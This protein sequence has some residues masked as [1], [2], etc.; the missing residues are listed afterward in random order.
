MFLLGFKRFIAPSVIKFFYYLALFVAVLSA[1][2]VVL[3]ALVEMRTLGAPQ[4]GAMIAGAAIG[5]P[6][7]ILLMRFSTEM[8][9]VLFEI[10]SR[11]GQI[12]DKL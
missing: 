12:R 9:L 11:L 2:G 3:Y 8:W 4:A 5:A 7:F 10:N 1:L 6:I